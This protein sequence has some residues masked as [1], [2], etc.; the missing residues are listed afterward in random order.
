MATLEKLEVLSYEKED[1]S[2]V[3]LISFEGLPNEW[4]KIGF[5]K[6]G[7]IKEIYDSLPEEVLNKYGNYFVWEDKKGFRIVTRI[8]PFNGTF[9]LLCIGTEKNI[10]EL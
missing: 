2:F 6:I 7:R 9:K 10:K 8:L 5:N 4:R 3:D 1:G